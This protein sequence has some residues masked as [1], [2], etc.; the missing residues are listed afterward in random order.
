[1]HIEQ[2]GSCYVQ[3]CGQAPLECTEHHWYMPSIR[4]IA[5]SRHPDLRCIYGQWAGAAGT[6]AY[7]NE[8]AVGASLYS[9]SWE[10]VLRGAGLLSNRCT[11][12]AEGEGIA[13]FWVY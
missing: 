5:G 7:N 12:I 9:H 1:M 3:S 6:G 4:Y 11:P 8:D 10:R 2:A 13:M